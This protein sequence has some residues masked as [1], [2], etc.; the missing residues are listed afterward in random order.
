MRFAWI[1]IATGLSGCWSAAPA[2][3]AAP[4]PSDGL[5]ITEHGW[6]PINASTVATLA[7]LRALLPAYR[8]VPEND[9][10]LEYEIYDGKQ[11]VGF[12]IINDD[13]SVFNVH[14]T[15][16]RVRVEAR[17]WRAGES[18]QDSKALSRCEC[19]G[20]NPT[21]YKTGE[22]V[23]VNFDRPCLEDGDDARGLR[24]LD[25]LVVQRVIWSVE[26]LG[27]AADVKDDTSDSADPDSP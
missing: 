24:V 2:P 11:K 26:P 13:A 21:C 10:Q 16:N 19:W 15:S 6:G 20:A 18:F 23:A 5:V 22:H 9:P 12:V 25:G 8:V 27:P 17:A 1:V 3:P 7:N 4:K 14:A